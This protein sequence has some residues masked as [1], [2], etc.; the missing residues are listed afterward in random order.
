LNSSSL[1]NAGKH[2][3]GH[4]AARPVET[5]DKPGSNR[6]KA[7]D[8]RDGHR[9]GCRLGRWR[10]TAVRDYYEY[11]TADK[12][13][14]QCRQTVTVILRP[15]ILNRHVPTLDKSGFAQALVECCDK[16]LRA[17]FGRTS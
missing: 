10:R 17:R 14:R 15:A 8:N 13:G 11:L 3:A 6:I 16:V 7:R 12:I 4:I 2:D 5:G 9:R 1:V